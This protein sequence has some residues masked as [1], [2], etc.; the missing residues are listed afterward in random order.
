MIDAALKSLKE[1]QRV[2]FCPPANQR[3]V[4]SIKRLRLPSLHQELLIRSNGLAVFHGYDR[5]FGVRSSEF[6]DLIKWNEAD[7]WKFAWKRDLSRYLC[8]AEDGW[9]YQW[10]YDLESLIHEGDPPVYWLPAFDMQAERLFSSFEEFFDR[11][12]LR[13]LREEYASASVAAYRHHGNLEWFNQVAYVPSLLLGGKDGDVEHTVKMRAEANM[14][15]NGDIY[16]QA[17]KERVDR[18]VQLIEPY[19]D[20]RGRPR[21]RVFF[22]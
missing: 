13:W 17:G 21:M 11:V 2:T 7:T 22:E 8:F 16:S 10:A 15:I 12:L 5:V 20:E 1:A 4:A 14:I 9:G 3:Q 19:T 18:P 6:R